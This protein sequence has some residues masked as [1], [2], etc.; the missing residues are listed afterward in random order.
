[1]INKPVIPLAVEEDEDYVI[2]QSNGIV[3]SSAKVFLS[4]EDTG[5]I[6]Q[7]YVCAICFE[8]Q[9]KPFPD[10]CKVCG[11]EMAERQSEYFAK[12]YKGCMRIG[13]S[14]SLADE[15]GALEELEERKRRELKQISVPQIIVPRLW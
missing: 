4:E 1:M 5:R 3:R 9:E 11:F 6:R 2:V 10:K 13:P 7:G 12:A 8:V 15:L 14:S